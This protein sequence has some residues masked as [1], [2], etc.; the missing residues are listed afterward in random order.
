[1]TLVEMIEALQ[2]EWRSTA[3]EYDVLRRDCV[4]HRADDLAPILAAAREQEKELGEEQAAHQTIATICFQAGVTTDDGTSV[5][6]VRNLAQELA[7]MKE[8][9]K[10]TYCLGLETVRKV[11]KEGQMETEIVDFVAADSLFDEELFTD[12]DLREIA[13]MAIDVVTT[14]NKSFIRANSGSIADSILAA[15]REK[16]AEVKAQ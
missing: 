5:S 16:K 4:L 3:N 8:Q 6:C 11:A 9:K 1:M 15:F 12:A 2:A 7:A 10:P 13:E 14:G